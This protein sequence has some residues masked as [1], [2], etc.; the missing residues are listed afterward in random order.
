MKCTDEVHRQ[1][2]QTTCTDKV[3]R[4][5]AQRPW[6]STL[7]HT[8]IRVP[9]KAFAIGCPSTLSWGTSQRVCHRLSIHPA[10]AHGYLAESLPSA[11]P[12]TL[13]ARTG[14]SQRAC[15]LRHHPPCM[16]ARVPRK[17]LA[18]GDTIHPPPSCRAARCPRKL[19][20]VLPCPG[21]P[22]CGKDFRCEL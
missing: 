6:E 9:R 12:S 20:P 3:H 17:E 13:Y 18:I 15:H 14:T 8:C 1:R 7:F 5:R 22:A 2:A 4:Q 19:A 11:T 21:A 16:R 10:C